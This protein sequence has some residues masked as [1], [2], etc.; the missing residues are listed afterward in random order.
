MKGVRRITN[1]RAWKKS[2]KAIASG[3][4]LLLFILVMTFPN[5]IYGGTTQITSAEQLVSIATQSKSKRLTD[6]YELTCNID[7]SQYEFAGIGSEEYPFAGTFDGNGYTISGL[8]V[9]SAQGSGLFVYAKDAT[10][11]NLKLKNANIN[12]EL[13]QNVSKVPIQAGFTGGIIGYASGCALYDCEVEDSTI[14]SNTQNITAN[15]GEGLYVGGLVGV[16]DAATVIEYCRVID[17]KVA[18]NLS[19]DIAALDRTT[20]HNGGVVGSLRNESWVI[21]SFSS[22]NLTTEVDMAMQTTVSVNN[23]F[24]GI[25]ASMEGESCGITR[26]HYSG[27]QRGVKRNTG[28][29]TEVSL[30]NSGICG[31]V[32]DENA[33]NI[34]YAYYD[35]DKLLQESGE[36]ADAVI[37]AL[38][39]ESG[40]NRGETETVKRIETEKYVL[41]ECFET[42]D[43]LG[44]TEVDY[45]KIGSYT[46]STGVTLEKIKTALSAEGI[47]HVNKWIM[48]E[49]AH[50]PVHGISFGA[51]LDFPG[52]GSVTIT[53]TKNSDG[54]TLHSFI[55]TES[56]NDSARQYKED[57]DKG[58]VQLTATVNEG[59]H[60]AGWYRTD[61]WYSNIPYT[62][63]DGW[64][65]MVT[66]T[67]PA[68]LPKG[69]T[70]E[71]DSLTYDAPAE[72]DDFYLAHFQAEIKFMPLGGTAS[73]TPVVTANYDYM[74][75]LKSNSAYATAISEV[76][77]TGIN[78]GIVSEKN[79]IFAGWTTREGGIEN[80][81][82]IDLAQITLYGQNTVVTETLTL[83]PIFIQD[84]SKIVFTTIEAG[85]DGEVSCFGNKYGYNTRTL[86]QYDANKTYTASVDFENQEDGTYKCILSL[87]DSDGKRI[88]D[89]SGWESAGYR[90]L[91][92]YRIETDSRGAVVYDEETKKPNAVRISRDM[93]TELPTETALSGIRLYEARFEYEVQYW[94]QYYKI[95]HYSPGVKTKTEWYEYGETFY[96]LDHHVRPT[97]TPNGWYT[98]IG[99]DINGD[100]VVNVY[101][102]DRKQQESERAK[103][104]ADTANAQDQDDEVP[105]SG[106]GVSLVGKPI[107]EPIYAFYDYNTA[108]STFST[109]AM[110]EFPD[111]SEEFSFDITTEWLINTRANLET[112][113]NEG[114]HFWG[115][116]QQR[117]DTTD[118]S[119]YFESQK[120]RLI[121]ENENYLWE[122]SLSANIFG[123]R[124]YIYIAHYYADINF[125]MK[126]NALKTVYRRYL[127][128]VFFKEDYNGRL[129]GV[130]SDGVDNNNDGISDGVI[131]GIWDNDLNPM[132]V[133]RPVEA[134]TGTLG[135]GNSATSQ[136]AITLAASPSN[137]EMDIK[138]YKFLG[139]INADEIGYDSSKSYEEQSY[140]YRYIYDNPDDT[141]VTS[142]EDRAKGFILSGDEVV[143]E[144]MTLIPVYTYDFTIAVESNI[145]SLTSNL[146]YR[147][148]RNTEDNGFDI[149]LGTSSDINT[150]DYP[151]TGWYDASGNLVT[152]ILNDDVVDFTVLDDGDTEGDKREYSFTANF[153]IRTTFHNSGE[154][155]ADV[156][157]T[158]DVNKVIGTVIS[159]LKPVETPANSYFIGWTW[160]EPTSSNK[161]EY[162]N[163]DYHVISD[164]EKQY[165]LSQYE[166]NGNEGGLE[167]FLYTGEE[168]IQ[169][170]MDLYPVYI[171][172]DEITDNIKVFS[173][174]ENEADTSAT[175]GLDA[176]GL[177]LETKCTNEGCMLVD[178]KRSSDNSN[179]KF[180][181]TLDEGATKYYISMPSLEKI[182]NTTTGKVD[183]YRADYG[184][185]ITYCGLTDDV[186]YSH[187]LMSG[188]CLASTNED[189]KMEYYKE[190]PL[191][192]ISQYVMEFGERYGAICYGNRVYT[193]SDNGIKTME[194][195]INTPV[196]QPLTFYVDVNMIY[197]MDNE[198]KLCSPDSFKI[199][200]ST[201]GTL[202]VYLLEDYTMEKYTEFHI[203]R[204]V[205]NHGDS[206]PVGQNGVDVNLYLQ[207]STTEDIEY[208]LYKTSATENHTGPVAGGVQQPDSDGIAVFSIGGAIKIK[209][210]EVSGHDKNDMFFFK[211]RQ[212]NS[213][214]YEYKVAVP[215]GETVAIVDVPFGE[216][217]IEQD[218]KWSWRYDAVN[219]ES[220]TVNVNSVWADGEVVT[221]E[222]KRN[223][224]LSFTDEENSE[225]T[226]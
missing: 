12:I 168:I 94:E 50:M 220:T 122:H 133:T 212:V 1:W 155:Y 138:G 40:A 164:L 196:T 193:K 66:E 173:N 120:D 77:K 102:A 221:F 191:D 163:G 80:A 194:E 11:T 92:W 79:G 129:D 210:N 41:E 26:C 128:N 203:G 156:E 174:R 169:A 52:A 28:R 126:D 97:G 25:A 103:F 48:D 135:S 190:V 87:K 127:D 149:Y 30:Y 189:G 225:L 157:R 53:E 31:Y 167:D 68:K 56:V 162:S 206:Y 99:G 147:I 205:M 58:K 114:Y 134:Y 186:L 209:L 148:K 34:S 91:G 19:T 10:I 43:Y 106:A 101:D 150:Y 14:G 179:W 2:T 21:D 207:K 82:M 161:G 59:Y 222:N 27:V 208:G 44:S 51:R 113:R 35:Y 78:A 116:T 3:L 140:M 110:S 192:I 170:P 33:K 16:A 72:D 98:G 74:D 63:L 177:Y 73:S 104:E 88:T 6:D 118:N 183:Y 7:L 223:E 213:D 218:T 160:L 86:E 81:S 146:D 108:S 198:H 171:H 224:K 214:V 39:R 46:E 109:L 90:F 105:F 142:H 151:F 112:V 215:A 143:S 8:T 20:I 139:W 131:Y 47:R 197:A 181:T 187:G 199:G 226:E 45:A 100:G 200:F 184:V 188:S 85:T 137:D 178:W 71:G 57:A 111:A 62:S 132:T 175:L 201:D 38:R 117:V 24:G 55:K 5:I 89:D 216:W 84:A 64:K 37:T 96:D 217:V 165:G 124:E 95:S 67:D 36:S 9:S 17:G 61:N 123:E 4:F 204:N 75:T 54:N 70:W 119:K 32:D 115:W 144:T 145:S 13:E 136:T 180:F 211:L 121:W 130:T 219:N 195:Y 172:L 93:K 166:A 69:T 76:K 49:S 159:T 15:I 65:E 153:K 107:T 154:N 202:N 176:T 60:F 182:L 42:F 29:G 185:K 141:F 23:Y 152:D 158:N 125:I 18:V 83:Y 22:A